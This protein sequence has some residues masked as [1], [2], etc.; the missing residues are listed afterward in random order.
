MSDI[1]V[2]IDNKDYRIACE[3][4]QQSH[5]I[6]L[7][8]KMDIRLKKLKQH[9]GEIGDVR[10]CVMV[11]LQLLDEASDNR[12]ENKNMQEQLLRLGEAH[13][14]LG[15]KTDILETELAQR[16]TEATQRL[17]YLAHLLMT[18]QAHD[19]TKTESEPE[20]ATL[21]NTTSA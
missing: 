21:S 2:T 3:S 9:F 13:K 19:R 5:L 15:Q 11:C 12:A 20:S 6:H 14:V 8:Q 10:L 18:Q 4:G 16:L 7:A 17:V 1:V